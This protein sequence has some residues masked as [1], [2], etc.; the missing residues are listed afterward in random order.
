M[1]VSV[2]SNIF[3]ALSAVCYLVSGILIIRRL[4]APQ[5]GGALPLR[6]ITFVAF[7]IQGVGL[8]LLFGNDQPAQ[9]GWAL[10]LSITV[11]LSVAVF[12]VESFMRKVSGLMGVFLLLAAAFSAMPVIFPGHTADAAI[13]TP[14]FRLHLLL[15][16][17]ASGF[18]LIAVVQAVLLVLVERQLKNPLAASR[19]TGLIASMPDLLAMERI[20]YRIVCLGFLCLTALVVLALVLNYQQH[21][22]LLVVSHRFLMTLVSWAVFAV[23]MY[24]RY[25]RGWRGRRALTWFWIGAGS[26][27]VAG[28][29]SAV[30]RAAML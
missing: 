7:A 23:L 11:F 30:L 26:L 15:A 3:L 6:L 24:G 27:A 29:V 12:L 16:F 5:A 17:C 21:G 10:A 4:S 25:M 8:A 2:V 28:F 1:S 18:I 13:W 22:T 20:L 19:N 9:F 14:V